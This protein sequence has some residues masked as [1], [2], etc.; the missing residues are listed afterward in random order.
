MIG[1]KGYIRDPRTTTTLVFQGS[2][3]G[4]RFFF[5]HEFPQILLAS[6]ELLLYR[7]TCVYPSCR[8]LHADRLHR[9]SLVPTIR[10]TVHKYLDRSAWW[11]SWRIVRATD[12][13]DCASHDT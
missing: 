2:G 1:R 8:A 4:S 5:T 11:L 7:P 6:L 13:R 3:I 12:H 9:H 10:P